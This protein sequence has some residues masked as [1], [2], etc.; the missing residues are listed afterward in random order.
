[1][2]AL[3]ASLLAALLLGACGTDAGTRTFSESDSELRVRSGEGF[4]IEIEASPG[5][6]DGWEVIGEPDPT[7]ARVVDSGFESDDPDAVGGSGIIWFE[8]E[9]VAAGTTEI[10]L[11]YCYRGC[12][13]EGEEFE[14]PERFD[15]IVG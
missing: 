12:G 1:M 8:F 13:G 14:H 4:R 9:A 6:G 11:E 15:V 3:I 5:V 2:P 10:V 7:V